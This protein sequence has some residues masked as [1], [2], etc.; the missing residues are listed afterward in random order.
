MWPLTNWNTHTTIPL[1]A[2]LFTGLC[3]LTQ[4]ITI[5]APEYSLIKSVQEDVLISVGIACSET[6]TIEWTFMSSSS[7]RD[8]A[9][10][11][12]GVHSNISEYYEDRLKTHNNGSITLLDLRL[13]DS[14][15]YILTVSEPTGHSKGSTIILK[16]TEVLYED[17]QYLAVFV[18]VLGGIAGF[19]MLSMW[20]LDK[21]YRRVKTWRQ[22]RK[23]PEHDET[24][25]QP[26]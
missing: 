1:L 4:A 6:P 24:E 15:V 7:R 10:W 12:P 17:L 14:G 22:M 25:L 18:T 21:V 2:V 8:V 5:T 23:Q 16:V 3:C 20:L 26:L 9:V 13:A 11:Q 19:L